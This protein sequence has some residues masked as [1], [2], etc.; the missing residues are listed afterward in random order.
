ML[1]EEKPGFYGNNMENYS[2]TI[3]MLDN[4]LVIDP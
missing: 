2:K 4:Y 3:S 1:V